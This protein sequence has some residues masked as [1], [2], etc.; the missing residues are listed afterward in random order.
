MKRVSRKNIAFSFSKDLH[1]V[2]EVKSGETVLFETRDAC[3]DTLKTVEDAL[4]YKASPEKTNPVTGPVAVKGAEPGDALEVLINKIELGDIGHLRIS[5]GAGVITDELDTPHA[6][7]IK[8]K[9][10]KIFFSDGIVIPIRPMIGTIGTAPAGEAIPALY[11]GYHGGNMDINTV[12]E[13]ARIFF[14]VNVSGALLSMGDVHASMGDGELS[15][16]G[17]NIS[18]EVA[19]TLNLKKS[20]E[21]QRPLIDYNDHWITCAGGKTVSKAIELATRDMTAF[22]SKYLG[23]SKEDSFLIIGACG[24]G[25]LG[26]A[27]EAGMDATA[28]VSI[29][30]LGILRTL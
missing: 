7:L 30:K 26:Q 5:K 17:M 18:A 29:P 4:R 14:P 12:R 16:G 20:F 27:A 22:M 3:N 19:V 8:V 15:G 2:L 9:D 24:D 1:P 13:G 21:L 6:R 11:P 10:G 23:I 25:G 28:F